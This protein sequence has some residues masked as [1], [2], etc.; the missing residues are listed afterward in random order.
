MTMSWLAEQN[1]TMSA[2]AAV[3][4]GSAA[5][6]IEPSATMARM[7]AACVVTSQLRRRPMSRLSTGTRTASITGAHR[8][9][10]T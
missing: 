3:A 9:F 8:N 4:S 2:S 10:S 5:G 6:S 7:S 1:A